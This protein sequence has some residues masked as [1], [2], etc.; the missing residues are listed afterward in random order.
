M[1]CY[2]R[3]SFRNGLRL[4]QICRLGFWV[5]SAFAMVELWMWAWKFD[6]GSGSRGFSGF[7]GS[8]VLLGNRISFSGDISLWRWKGLGPWFVGAV[9][10]CRV[11]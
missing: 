4:A 10:T 1:Y 3:R 7:T 5:S 2:C 11:V 8:V 6:R 9:V